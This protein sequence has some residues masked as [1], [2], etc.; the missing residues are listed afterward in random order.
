MVLLTPYFYPQMLIFFYWISSLQNQ[1]IR[2][3]C[4]FFFLVTRFRFI[5]PGYY[6]HR[7]HILGSGRKRLV[8]KEKIA[9]ISSVGREEE[10][11]Q[12]CTSSCLK[13]KSIFTSFQFILFFA[14]TLLP[15]KISCTILHLSQKMHLQV[16]SRHVPSSADMSKRSCP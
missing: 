5:I 4:G 7:R 9:S 8:Q 10:S 12:V 6:S 13:L 16:M 15:S 14:M 11:Q 3:L 1:N 2:N